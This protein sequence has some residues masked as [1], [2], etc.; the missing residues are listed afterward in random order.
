MCCSQR[1]ESPFVR[2]SGCQCLT[3]GRP[4]VSPTTLHSSSVAQSL[5]L[6][7]RKVVWC[8]HRRINHSSP[9][10][11]IW[12]ARSQVVPSADWP[13]ARALA[14][15]TAMWYEPFSEEDPACHCPLENNSPHSAHI[16][17]YITV[18]RVAFWCSFRVCRHSKD[19][20]MFYCSLTYCWIVVFLLFF[21]LHFLL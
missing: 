3:Q 6:N 20:E 19:T 9:R 13:S 14:E 1:L 16:S 12:V 18:E 11:A 10:A 2:R 21:V 17:I 8:E 4:P 5:T 7:Q 15:L